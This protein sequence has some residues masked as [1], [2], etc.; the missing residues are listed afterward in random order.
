MSLAK[1]GQNKAGRQ[2]YTGNKDNLKKAQTYNGRF[3]REA[4]SFQSRRMLSKLGVFLRGSYVCCLQV[5]R[6]FLMYA[7]RK[8]NV[9][10]AVDFSPDSWEDARRCKLQAQSCE[11]CHL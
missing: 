8:P 2:T 4:S 3:A 11:H 5:A 7:E 9:D 6:N 1:R 10:P